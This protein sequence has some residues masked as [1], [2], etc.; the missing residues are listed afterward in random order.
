MKRKEKGRARG[1]LG[2]EWRQGWDGR[3]Y[4]TDFGEREREEKAWMRVLL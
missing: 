3:A 1:V 2:N 4:F